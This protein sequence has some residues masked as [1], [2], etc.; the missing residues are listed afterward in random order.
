MNISKINTYNLTV[1]I[2]TFNRAEHLAR[3]L[4]YY[5]NCDAPFIFLILDSSI[6]NVHVK[7][8][9]VVD[10]LPS[11]YNLL[12]FPMTICPIKKLYEG[13]KLVKT[14]YTVICADDDIIFVNPIQD[15]IKYLA[16]HPEYVCVDGIYLN[17]SPVNSQMHVHVEYKNPSIDAQHAGARVFKFLQRYE[18]LFYGVYR[19]D[20]IANIFSIITELD[21]LH[22][23]ELFQ[24]ISSLLLGKQHR[25]STF[26][27]AR[28]ACEMAEPLY[29]KW[30]PILWFA[31][32]PHEFFQSYILYRDKLYHF[33]DKYVESNLMNKQEFEK[34]MDLAHMVYFSNNCS[35]AYFYNYLSRLWSDDKYVDYENSDDE[36]Y[37]NLQTPTKRRYKRYAK[38]FVKRIKYIITICLKR[39]NL[40]ALRKL[41]KE[42]YDKTGTQWDCELPF[43]IEWFAGR[44]EF[45]TAYI[46]LC[47]Y[48]SNKIDE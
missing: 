2:P 5:S 17:F 14:E 28:Q 21:S 39:Y 6:D 4:N 16:A 36:L 43:E 19:K 31:D 45:R 25:L 32:N 15:A 33:F 46:E 26:Y 29:E 24:S 42:V 12:R 1:I 37:R 7:N 44:P 30:H 38:N 27:A 11:N 41:R 20:D 10:S 22:F 18:S 23:K 47:K 40:M 13:L 48:A 8:Q 34:T 35:S 3:L 9:E